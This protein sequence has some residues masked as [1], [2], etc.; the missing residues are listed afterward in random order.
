MH[1]VTVRR[2]LDWGSQS[3][4]ARAPSEECG[5]GVTGTEAW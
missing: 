4:I 2:V 3:L 5:C 1:A